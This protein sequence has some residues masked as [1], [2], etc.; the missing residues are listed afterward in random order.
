MSGG[1]GD[2]PHVIEPA[3][4][5]HARFSSEDATATPWADVRRGLDEADLAWLTTVRPD[6]H[7][8]VTPL[9]FVWLDAAVYF[10]TGP[11]ERKA[12]NLTSSPHCILTTGC[13]ALDRGLDV[14]IE[15]EATVVSDPARSRQV[16]RGFAAKYLPREGAKVF[17]AGLRE[18]TFIVDGKTLLYE[19]KPTAVFGFG[20][21]EEFS[22]TR[23]RF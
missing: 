23:W 13:N 1:S 2:V 11:S 12:K 18:D 21:G 17:H 20:K 10:T 3:G 6:G 9:I 5:L 16:A 19:V 4:E 15:G 22:Q 7:P 8:H 14:V